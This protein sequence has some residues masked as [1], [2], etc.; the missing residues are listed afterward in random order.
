MGP[1]SDSGSL[2]ATDGEQDEER[3]LVP[4]RI[5]ADR[6]RPQATGHK[7]KEAV[8]GAVQALERNEI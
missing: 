1:K 6:H 3:T 7:T 4:G 2:T 8:V 5:C